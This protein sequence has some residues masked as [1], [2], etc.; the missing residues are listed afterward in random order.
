MAVAAAALFLSLGGAGYAAIAIPA[1]SVGSAQ[2]KTFA[3]TNSK[4]AASSVGFRKI[5]PGAVGTVRIDRNEVQL[6]IKDACPVGQ[7][8]TAVGIT[9]NVMCAPL[10]SAETNSAAA[11][12]VMVSSP[13]V[14]AKVS[15]LTLNGGSAYAVQANPYITVT[16]ST[17]TSAQAQHV[18]VTCTLQDGTS[19]TVAAQREAS[20][21]LPAFDSTPAPQ[22][23]TASI[24]LVVIVPNSAVAPSMQ[25][26][27]VASV[28]DTTG[29][30]AGK[31]SADPATVTGQGQI[32]ATQLASA[33]TATTPT[34]TTTGTTTTGTTTTGTTTTGTTTTGTTTT[35]TTTTPNP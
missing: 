20:F 22:V 25:V 10:A 11:P 2:L 23:Q 12:A 30:D 32:Y 4:L 9:G 15:A 19:T 31:A 24:P 16:P 26:S 3:V 5:M 8:I 18:A 28:T 1:H 35:G 33:T 13:T 6:R 29:S 7:A 27:C 34:T 17:N 14:A 21:D